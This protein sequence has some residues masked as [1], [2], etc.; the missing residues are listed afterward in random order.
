MTDIKI[1]FKKS[2]FAS[3]IPDVVKTIKK[4][5]ILKGDEQRLEAG[6]VDVIMG[7]VACGTVALHDYLSGDVFSPAGFGATLLVVGGVSSFADHIG[8][9][10]WN[11]QVDM[12]GTAQDIVNELLLKSSNIVLDDLRSKFM[13]DAEKAEFISIAELSVMA[14]MPKWA[15]NNR[16]D[17]LKITVNQAKHA[18]TVNMD[19]II[20]TFLGRDI[21]S[22]DIHHAGYLAS[23][24]LESQLR[25][26]LNIIDINEVTN[27]PAIE[28][29][30]LE[31]NYKNLPIGLMS[32]FTGVV[33]GGINII[34]AGQLSKGMWADGILNTS[35]VKVTLPH[36]QGLGNAISDYNKSRDHELDLPKLRM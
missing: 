36:V 26:D 30:K 2:S 31:D 9:N 20:P 6:F 5:A 29:K 35:D 34:K 15:L 10:T 25:T 21:K 22:N 17:E 33:T 12:L 18:L 23:E 3:V 1:K 19:D 27:K 13:D 8:R 14:A 7:G 32:V 4:K 11:N 24:L 28:Y 16:S